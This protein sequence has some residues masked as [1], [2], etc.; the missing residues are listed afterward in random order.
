MKRLLTAAVLILAVAI[1]SG[2]A[3][4]V[5]K[6]AKHHCQAEYKEAKREAGKLTTHK[7]R[8]DAKRDAKR[9]YDECLEK[10]K[11]KT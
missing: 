8:V 3:T 7:A 1:P 2:A 6:D 11:H 10:A 9:K 4:R 5:D